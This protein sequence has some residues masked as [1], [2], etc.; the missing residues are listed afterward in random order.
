M[1]SLLLSS[2]LFVVVQLSLAAVD[3]PRALVLRVG[4]VAARVLVGLA[5]LCPLALL[6]SRYSAAFAS[7]NAYL[8]YLGDLP[9]RV[10]APVMLW[11]L[12]LA[13]SGLLAHNA[14]AARRAGTTAALPAVTGIVRITRHPVLWGIVTWSAFHG[15]ANGD[16]ASLVFFGSFFVSALPAMWLLDRRHAE[17]WGADF[18]HYAEQTSVLP[19]A[20]IVR[21]KTKLSWRELGTKPILLSLLAFA[22]VVSFHPR[23]FGAYPLPGMDD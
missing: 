8:W 16:V 12:F 7:G 10:A 11:A 14:V 9:Q 19:F 23:L 17:T 1:S 13:V 3:V 20:A 21:G 6:A 5:T 22:L 2:L 15:F 4:Q 18:V